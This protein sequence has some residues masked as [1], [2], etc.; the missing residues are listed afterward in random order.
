MD[1]GG[2]GSAGPVLLVDRTR[3]FS[4]T[5]GKT[6]IAVAV[7]LTLTCGGLGI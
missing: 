2:G 7:L 3:S 6:K 1:R 4:V 5:A